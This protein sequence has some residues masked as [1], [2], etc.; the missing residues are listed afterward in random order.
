MTSAQVARNKETF[1]RLI[2]EAMPNGQLDVIRDM[3][4][5]ECVT[6]RAGFANLY[7]AIGDAIPERGNFLNWLEA[8]WKPLSE[9]F[10]GQKMKVDHVVGDGDTVMMKWHMQIVHRGPFAGAPATQKTIDWEE[11]GIAHFNEEGKIETLWFMCEE[12]KL[13]VNIGYKL[14]LV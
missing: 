7:N 11:I 8:G 13:A 12:L 14:E 5:P 4:T 10:G 1:R 3:V 6:L 2:E 9:A